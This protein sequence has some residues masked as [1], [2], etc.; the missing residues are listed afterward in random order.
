MPSFASSVLLS[1][2][3]IALLSTA[4]P[5]PPPDSAT[6][7]ANAQEAQKL[8]D[9]F[10]LVNANDPC[11]DGETAC[12]DGAEA[13]C[14]G[15]S[16]QLQECPSDPQ[17][18]QCFVLPSVRRSGTILACTTES[19]A[20][21]LIEGLGATGG[22]TGSDNTTDP[23][24]PSATA[25]DPTDPL[26]TAT[27]TSDPSATATDTSDPVG[28]VATFDPNAPTT[29]TVTVTLSDFTPTPTVTLD[30]VTQT[31]DPAAANAALGS[32]ASD[33]ATIML[34]TDAPAA[35]GTAPAVA[36]NIAAAPT[37]DATTIMLTTTPVTD[38]PAPTDPAAAV[39]A[40][41]ATTDPAA[42][43]ATTTADPGYGYGGY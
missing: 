35:T 27:D 10:Q 38:T 21:A 33:A 24:D 13:Q 29:V 12:V 41:A 36:G 23:T 25:T 39:A 34:T 26:A 31:L 3:S 16:W 17:N 9:N 40:N 37:Q 30:S 2:L 7:L 15:T 14:V 6:L 42:A 4:A 11:T 28:A 22:I 19:I 5:T 20:V 18:L 43:A 32:L 1:L 8:N